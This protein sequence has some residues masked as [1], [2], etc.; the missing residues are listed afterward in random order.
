MHNHW[1]HKLFA[2]LLVIM[3]FAAVLHAAA[4]IDPCLLDGSPHTGR[5][6]T[7]ACPVCCSVWSAAPSAPTVAIVLRSDVF[8]P[9][10]ADICRVTRNQALAPNPRGPPSFHNP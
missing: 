8:A 1:S 7:H 9:P 10:A 5:H 2:A 3:A 4:E 6:A